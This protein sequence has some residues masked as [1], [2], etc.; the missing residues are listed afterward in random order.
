[1]KKLFVILIALHLMILP[2]PAHA[3]GMG[4]IT[5]IGVASVGV[6]LVA[7]CPI[8]SPSILLYMAGAAAYLMGEMAAAKQ[9]KQQLKNKEA[10]TKKLEEDGKMGGETQL[11]TMEAQ[12]KSKQEELKLANSR[13][14][15]AMA[16]V[17]AITAAAVASAIEIPPFFPPL[18]CNSAVATG[19]GL[20]LGAGVVAAYEFIS[21]NGIMGALMGAVAGAV[22][23][24]SIGINAFSG[25]GPTRSIAMGAMAVLVG[26][27]AMEAGKAAEKIQKDIDDL[28]KMIAEFKRETDG[29]G[30]NTEDTTS[31]ADGGVLAG[32]TSG[33][34]SGDSSSG[35]ST[36]GSGP[37]ISTP[38]TEL[39]AGFEVT[40]SA[41]CLNSSQQLSS[42]C[43][44]P[45]TFT[46]PDLKMFGNQPDLQQVASKTAE[47]GNAAASGQIGKANVAAASLA[48]MAGKM[49]DLLKKNREAANKKLVASGKKAIDY[50]KQTQDVLNS[51]QAAYQKQTASQQPQL[52][53]YGLDKLSLDPAKDDKS[54]Q[55]INAASTTAAIAVPTSDANAAAAVAAGADAGAVTDPNALAKKAPG[56]SAATTLGKNLNDY[57]SNAGDISGN[58]EETLWKQVS[59][60]YLLN[61]SRLF[62]RNKLPSQ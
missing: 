9:Q 56:E 33:S 20:P 61:Y 32:T 16:A 38:V 44:N 6:A 40:D 8:K 5:G 53:A 2:M 25:I 17:A 3:G 36:S 12:L 34:T 31:G 48:S 4:Q 59:N 24:S 45:M 1:M 50:D 18:V 52:A 57:E 10:E 30:P 60:R 47:F 23:A 19:V 14:M 39:P 55:K 7:A 42:N 41:S 35:G 51:M 15:W 54:G 27:S 37:G 46:S 22:A 58:K 21:G 62:D 13:K 28:N 29:T 49:S 11:A 43:S 26:L